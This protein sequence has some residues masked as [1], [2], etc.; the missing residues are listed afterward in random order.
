MEKFRYERWIQSKSKDVHSLLRH[1]TSWVGTNLGLS[2]SLSIVKA[3]GG[4]T[5]V[6]SNL[7]KESPF[8][9]KLPIGWESN[10]ANSESDIRNSHT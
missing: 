7:I 4:T 8:T 9:A 6:Q 3:H 5:E 2:I 1:K 10:R